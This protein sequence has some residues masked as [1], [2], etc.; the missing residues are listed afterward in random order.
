VV[1]IVKTHG[2]WVRATPE[3]LHCSFILTIVKVLLLASLLTGTFSGR[4]VLREEGHPLV[5]LVQ[6]GSCRVCEAWYTSASGFISPG[7]C[8]VPAWE[9]LESANDTWKGQ[10]VCPLHG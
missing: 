9:L 2:Q 3:N 8:P 4:E 6:Q 7:P 10:E 5:I 1:S